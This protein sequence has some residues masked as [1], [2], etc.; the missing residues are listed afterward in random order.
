MNVVSSNQGKCQ[1]WGWGQSSVAISIKYMNIL[2]K[3]R[4]GGTG[5]V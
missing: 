1:L 5:H 3:Q 4:G 2:E